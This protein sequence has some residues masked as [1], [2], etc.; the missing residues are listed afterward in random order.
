MVLFLMY[1]DTY[2][3]S[4]QASLLYNSI[5]NTELQS[6]SNSFHHEDVTIEQK[7]TLNGEDYEGSPEEKML[8]IV[9]SIVANPIQKVILLRSERR[10]WIIN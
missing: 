6:N 1:A 2:H 4:N 5:L 9:A 10:I 7:T 8:L 3:W